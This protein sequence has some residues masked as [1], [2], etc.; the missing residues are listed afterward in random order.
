MRDFNDWERRQADLFYAD[1]LGIRRPRNP[2]PQT[3][4]EPTSSS[5]DL[6]GASISPGRVFDGIVHRGLS[7]E[8]VLDTEAAEGESWV[9]VAMPRSATPRRRFRR[10]AMVVQRALGEHGLA[11]IYVLGEDI[12]EHELYG[13]DGLIRPDILVLHPEKDS[14]ASSP[15]AVISESEQEW[16]LGSLVRAA[17]RAASFPARPSGATSG[18]AF[19]DKIKGEGAPSDWVKRENAIV[20][21]LVSGNMPDAL[22]NW[23]KVDLTYKD[24]TRNLTGSVQVLPDY[25]A[26]GSDDDFVHVP[27]DPVSAQL[28]ADKFDAILPTARICHAIYQQAAE[29][30]RI[31][32]IERDYWQP[33]DALRRT[34]KPG[35]AQTST[36]AYLE[37]S[38]A[39]Q[40]KM[41]SAGI[42]PGELVAG[43]KKDVVIARR[44]HSDAD[45][46]AFH[47]FYDSKGFPHEPCYE[48]PDH[49]P[50]PSC[51]KESP[52]LAHT[53][54]FSDYSQ[55]VRLV[56]AWMIVNGERKKV[57]DVLADKD[58][59]FLVSNEGPIVPPRIPNTVKP[60]SGASEATVDDTAEVDAPTASAVTID[61]APGLGTSKTVAPI[62]TVSPQRQMNEI[63]DRELILIARAR[64]VAEWIDRK[65]SAT[66]DQARA[67]SALMARLNLSRERTLLDKLRPFPG[68]KIPDDR[69]Q[70]FTTD[71]VLADLLKAPADAAGLLP[72]FDLLYDYGVVLLP[73]GAPT[74]P[75]SRS[76]IASITRVEARLERTRFDSES[77]AVERRAVQ[78]K[79][80]VGNKGMLHH[81]VDMEAIPADIWVDKSK[82]PLE[83]AKPVV[84][85]LRR[86]RE[87]N[88]SWHAGTYVGHWWN[89]FSVDAFIIANINADGFWARDKV[90]EFFRA[91]N[92][93]CED[94]AAPGR[95]AWKGIYND[96]GLAQEM[97]RLYGA[98]RV[99]HDVPGHGPGPRMHVHLDVR[100]LTV[101]FDTT[102]G[103]WIK[104]GRV[105]LRP[106]ASSTVAASPT[107][108]P[109]RPAP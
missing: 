51:N 26:V 90:R 73:P 30:N 50:K 72:I 89:D 3:T 97:D 37:H 25:L 107:A 32:A 82:T 33:K 64:I 49:T 54:R 59:S 52:T 76:V 53:R 44:L 68:R 12:Q 100:P 8:A 27:L 20:A 77:A 36:A 1:L 48:N 23:I 57:A 74:A 87:R 46:I 55:G 21:E 92:A 101:P 60:A 14:P 79:R 70:L 13:A 6:A 66:I 31:N 62:A 18:H 22:L 69:D 56:N 104:A 91:L 85:L 102:T 58:Q 84:A 11:T 16:S 103:F 7:P 47:G 93:A 98:G 88:K 65:F 35:R 10:G 41:K 71:A 105:V 96:T 45:K 28:V 106:P 38:E 63:L 19:M 81:C 17:I 24:S 67:D 4:T 39:I 94:D 2:R 95:F 75:G 29:K 80:D 61:V 9:I 42:A 86:L 40:A 15:I 43:H 5:V 109:S 99:L 34:A 83:V 78:F 108:S